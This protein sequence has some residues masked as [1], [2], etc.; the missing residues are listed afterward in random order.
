MVENDKGSAWKATAFKRFG[1]ATNGIDVTL[2]SKAGAGLRPVPS[3]C[4]KRTHA[5]MVRQSG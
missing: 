1:G 3:V 5:R 2:F 4:G